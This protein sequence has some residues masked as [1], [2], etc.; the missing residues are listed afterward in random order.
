MT[1]LVHTMKTALRVAAWLVLTIVAGCASPARAPEDALQVLDKAAAAMGGWDT[2]NRITRQEIQSSG[3]DWEPLQ[4]SEPTAEPRQINSFKQ[5]I[6]VDYRKHRLRL[7]FD[8]ARTYPTAAPVKFVEVIDGDTGMLE[9]N[10]ERLHPSRLAT[11]LRDYNRMPIRLLQ[12][13]KNASDLRVEGGI[14]K[15]TDSG[16][17]VQLQFDS[18]TGLPLRVIYMEDDPIFGDTPNELSYSD[19]HDWGEV[20]LPRTQI[21]KLDGK[22]IREERIESVTTD[23]PLDEAAFAIPESVRTQPENGERIVSQWVLRRVVMGVAYLDYGRTQ[24]IELVDVAA[25]IVHIRGG[26]HHSMA[27][28]MKDHLI[29]VEAPLF[30]ER[31]VAVISALE[32]RF[33]GKPIKHLV[34]THFHFDHSGG[35]RAYVAKGATVVVHEAIVPFTEEMISRPHTL[36]PDSL[37]KLATAPAARIQAVGDLSTLTDGER[38][39]ELRA[40]PNDHAAGMIIAYLP[41]EQVVFVSDLYSPPGPVSNPS[42]I[43]ERTRAAAFRGA[44]AK[45]RLEVRTIVGGHGIAGPLRDLDNALR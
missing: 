19:W 12:V 18:Q 28:E 13:A 41:R 39:V 5:A 34:L 8:A 26:S 44:L 35:V 23:P 6:L 27:I 42:V 40:V 1:K 4:T 14:L 25:G 32:G 24:K 17:P 43:F 36:R 2:L 15:Y 3:V 29:V 20:R 31:S 21:T 9:S 16:L 22:K 10:K 30:D 11:R 33:P 37:A 38:V 45:Q 7:T